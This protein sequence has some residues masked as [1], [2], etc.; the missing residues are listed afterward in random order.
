M[1]GNLSGHGP[2]DISFYS[3]DIAYIGLLEISIGFLTQSILGSIYL[4]SSLKILNIGKGSL[5]HY[6]LEKHSSRNGNID[7]RCIEELA[8]LIVSFLLSLT[9][10]GDGLIVGTLCRL[11]KLGLDIILKD[12]LF[13][14][15][16]KADDF[17]GVMGL[18]KLG[19][20]KGIPAC[21]LKVGKLLPSYLEKLA[22]V[23][24][25][26]FFLVLLIYVCHFDT[27]ILPNVDDLE[28]KYACGSFNLNGLTLLALL[29][30][31][32]YRA[33]I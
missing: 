25:G 8:A 5:A 26:S 27:L 7:G 9:V 32:S 30:S 10:C 15:L 24:L 22:H 29:E 21:C 28:L 12:L 1:N 20:H 6:S 13:V 18:I 3:E 2:E 31:T 4:T 33:F 19:D 11:D 17:I 16:I 23:L 14:C